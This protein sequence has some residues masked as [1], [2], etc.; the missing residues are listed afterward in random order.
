[1]NIL[2]TGATGFLGKNIAERLHKQGMRITATG[3]NELIGTQLKRRGIRFIKANLEDRH[4]IIN[5]CAG[6]D[7]VIHCGART[8]QTGPYEAYYAANVHGTE[9]IIDG[10]ITHRVRRLIHISTPA[11]FLAH[12]QRL[13][14]TEHDPLPK[15]FINHYAKTKWLSE[16]AT[17]RAFAKGLPVITLRPR[18]LYG[19]GDRALFPGLIEASAAGIIPL[20]NKGS[21]LTDI[22]Y[23]DNAVDAVLLAIN[24]PSAA[25]G[26]KYNITN[27]EPIIIKEGLIRLFHRLQLPLRT[28]RM[29]YK[30]ALRMAEALEQKERVLPAGQNTWLTTQLLA[31]LGHSQTLSIEK[32]KRE[33]GY[34]PVVSNDEG[35]DRFVQWWKQS[36]HT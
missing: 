10:C 7:T 6:I 25:L 28:K 8:T 32:A 11:I 9:N 33:L 4:A 3:R 15:A 22:T 24:A 5:A 13:N 35:I 31:T 29:P 2:I 14:I 17:D 20:F 19:P 36:P 16:Q 18:T 21:V 12:S 30:I 23:I 1:M 34:R 27:G 26:G